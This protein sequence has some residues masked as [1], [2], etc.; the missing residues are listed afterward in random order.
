M[1]QI[2]PVTQG[3]HAGKY[4][5]QP[6]S[7]LFAART[8]VAKLVLREFA[9]VQS[10]TLCAFMLEDD[11]FSPVALLGLEPGQNLFVDAAGRWSGR[12]VPRILTHYPFKLGKAEG[13]RLILCIDE[14]SGLLTGPGEGL[15]L[16]GESG[17]PTEQAQAKANELVQYQQ[18]LQATQ[19]LCARLNN[20]GLLEPWRLQVKHEQGLRALEGLY[21]INERALT[22]MPPQDFAALREGGGLILVYGQLFSMQHAQTLG[23]IAGLRALAQGNQATADLG[24]MFNTDNGTL[25][26]DN[27]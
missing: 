5:R 6:D 17:T 25:S 21:K 12:H 4:W 16:F 24:N 20:A 22:T 2:Y 1:N 18:E 14:G 27:L 11:C 10:Y 3:R 26:F 7:M 15:A 19:A 8:Q 23:Q 9:A 13:D